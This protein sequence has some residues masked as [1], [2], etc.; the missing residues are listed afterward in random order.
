M[1]VQTP[2]PNNTD[3]PLTWDN[4]SEECTLKNRDLIAYLDRLTGYDKLYG[5]GDEPF[6][7]LID[8]NTGVNKM[9]YRA[10]TK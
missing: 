1:Y 6:C 10:K 4:L 8:K 5:I 2:N 3:F 9:F 7:I